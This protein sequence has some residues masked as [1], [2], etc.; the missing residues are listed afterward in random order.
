[1]YES[2]HSPLK[3]TGA[4][5]MESFFRDP[6]HDFIKKG[7]FLPHKIVLYLVAMQRRQVSSLNRGDQTGD[8]TIS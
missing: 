5:L 2:R 7:C 6:N 3:R 4:H 1:M 8:C